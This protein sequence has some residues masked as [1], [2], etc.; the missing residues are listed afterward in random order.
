M[1]S[2]AIDALNIAQYRT[3]SQVNQA[4]TDALVPYATD[5]DVPAATAGLMTQAQGD[6]RYFATSASLGRV[7]IVRSNVTPPQI[8][9][10]TVTSGT[11]LSITAPR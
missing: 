10:M 2:G 7:S 8:R 6:A 4:I 11:P 1:V 3:E 9:A 5:A